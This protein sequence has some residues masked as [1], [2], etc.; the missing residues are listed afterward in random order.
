MDDPVR[1]DIDVRINSLTSSVH[2]ADARALLTPEVLQQIVEAVMIYRREE[3]RQ[4]QDR[5]HDMRIG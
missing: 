1:G 3:E 5:E 2:L 4:Q